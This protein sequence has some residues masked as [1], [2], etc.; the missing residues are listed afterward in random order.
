MWDA[1]NQLHVERI[2]HVEHI[3]FNVMWDP[4]KLTPELKFCLKADVNFVGSHKTLNLI[5]TS[6]TSFFKFLV[7]MARRWSN[8]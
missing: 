8:D 5:C 1:I 6:Y 4:I 3:K 7:R 2:K